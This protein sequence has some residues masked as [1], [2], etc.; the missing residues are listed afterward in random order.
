MTHMMNEN[1]L[2]RNASGYYD[3]PC[4]K[5]VTAP[6]KAGEIWTHSKS[7]AYMLVIANRNGVCSTLRLSETVRD[8]SV[9]VTCK[10]PMYTTPIM[11]GYCFDNLLT[12][13]V[14]KVKAEEFIAVQREIGKTLG[15]VFYEDLPGEH[16]EELKKEVVMLTR[17]RDQARETAQAIK[18]DL[19]ARNMACDALD[20]QC[21]AMSAELDKA[22][23][24]KEM[25]LTL[26][27]KLIS[28]RGGAANDQAGVL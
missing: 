15:V 4:Y 9:T 12:D 22:N 16:M 26:L 2:K 23:V 25:Y 27:D 3:E 11:L 13:F 21:R 14:K 5:A 19:D 17:E 8:D 18:F 24:Y 7:G 20:A 1:D 10:V 6:P 28:S